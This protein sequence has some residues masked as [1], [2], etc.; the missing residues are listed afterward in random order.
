MNSVEF[1]ANLYTYRKGKITPLMTTQKYPQ[2]VDNL[3]ITLGNISE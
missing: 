3:W 1:Q 2:A